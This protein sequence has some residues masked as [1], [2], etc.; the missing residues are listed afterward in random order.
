MYGHLIWVALKAIA[1][2]FV[3]GGIYL[4]VALFDNKNG[5]PPERHFLNS[6]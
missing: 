1:I 5:V 6:L 3:I 4:Q 2:L